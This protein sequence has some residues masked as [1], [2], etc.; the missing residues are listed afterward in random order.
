ML[1]ILKGKETFIIEPD[2]EEDSGSVI[3]R[4]D[5]GRREIPRKGLWLDRTTADK[6]RV[7]R[8]EILNSMDA[9]GE[10]GMRTFGGG[11]TKGNDSESERPIFTVHLRCK[12]KEGKVLVMSRDISLS[13]EHSFLKSDVS[14]PVNETAWQGDS[15]GTLDGE[16]IAD[17][18]DASQLWDEY[19]FQEYKKVKY[20][21]GYDPYH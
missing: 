5:N 8:A 18:M 9:L 17:R 13:D 14:S 4:V 6:I 15:V 11:G 19:F 16:P 7:I 12:T 10:A 1:G 2:P 20:G 3:H 21:A